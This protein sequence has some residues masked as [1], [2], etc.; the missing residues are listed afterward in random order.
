MKTVT[1][2]ILFTLH[3][4]LLVRIEGFFNHSSFTESF[5][6]LFFADSLTSSILWDRDKEVDL[7]EIKL[8]RES[9]F[10]VVLN[11]IAIT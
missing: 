2:P 10:D 5:M 1:G 8:S 11:S 4:F 7:N 6:K 9:I 3:M